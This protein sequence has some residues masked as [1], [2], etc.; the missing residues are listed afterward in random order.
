MRACLLSVFACFSA[1]PT[2]C[3]MIIRRVNAAVSATQAVSGWLAFTRK[4]TMKEFIIFRFVL[5][6][7]KTYLTTK[8]SA[9]SN[10]VQ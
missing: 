4:I 7:R 3:A 5:I 8:V 2:P 6:S 10:S 9:A 1:L